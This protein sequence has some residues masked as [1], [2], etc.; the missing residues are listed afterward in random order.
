[1]S[2]ERQHALEELRSRLR[3]W[4]WRTGREAFD[5]LYALSERGLSRRDIYDEIAEFVTRPPPGT[6]QRTLDFAD[7]LLAHLVGQCNQFDI[8]R[9]HGDPPDL[10]G[11][12]RHVSEQAAELLRPGRKA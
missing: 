3:S 12:I 10:E 9:L 8:I 4:V 1:M 2:D 7:E 6:D 5:A 11:L